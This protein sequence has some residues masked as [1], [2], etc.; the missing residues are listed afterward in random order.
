MMLRRSVV[1]S[2]V[3][4][5][6][7]TAP[8]TS[9]AG[10]D[11]P[12]TVDPYPDAC[13]HIDPTA[14]LLPWPSS[15]YLVD[16]PSTA[17]GRRVAIPAEAMPTDMRGNHVDPA[18]YSGRDGF[19][20][21]TSMMISFPGELDDSL[22]S[23]EEHVPDTLALGSTTVIV[24]METGERVAHFAELDRWEATDPARAPLYLR[25]TERL[26]PNTRYAV[27]IS[28]LRF[29]D[30]S[31]VAPSPY[32]RALRDGTDLAGVDVDA[33]RAEL[34][35]VFVALDG[36]GAPRASL[37]AAW[38][39][40]TGSDEAI[41]SDLIAMRDTALAELGDGLSC[42][43]VTVQDT[44][45]GDTLP[46]GVWR[47]IE[48]TITMP[49]FL[50][51]PSPEVDDARLVR[52]ASGHPILNGTVEAPFLILIPTSVRDRVQAGGEAGRMVV[53]GHGI[54]GERTE[55]DS[56]W[57]IDSASAMGWV[58]IATDW[59]GM[60][61]PDA[62]RLLSTLSASF[63][64]FETTPERLH[65]GVLNTMG[66]MR[67]FSGACAELTELAVPLDDASTVVAYDAEHPMF[68]GNSLGA[69]L[70]GTFA[71]IATDTDRFALGVGGGNWTLLV[72]R[73]DAWRSFDP[74]IA[75]GFPDALTRNLLILMTASLWDPIDSANYAPH[76]L[77]DPLP[78]T[79]IKHVMMQI[80]IGDVAVSNATSLFVARSAGMLLMTPSS[81]D[82]YGLTGVEGTSDS[83]L[84]IYR[85]PGIDAI[86]PGPH[87]PGMSETHN[88][89]RTLP[90]ALLQLDAFL[91]PDGEVIH[92]CD[93]ACDPD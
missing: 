61:R 29:I 36:V 77:S 87:D 15:R 22:L 13:E 25:A 74:L 69:I 85:L 7:E 40:A 79:P 6:C 10:S 33:R 32:F 31:A 59:W 91:R 66:L 86:A 62:G 63:D 34:E 30:G 53:Y 21:L 90:A 73:S 9:D 23:D 37:I 24:D 83:G 51:G 12:V 58:V 82:P 27:G 64:D 43:V 42:T 48:G 84:T 67:S 11:A 56:R 81:I 68:Y 76:W 52:D 44:D 26:R 89:V 93:G 47:R 65:Q 8:P 4:L 20:P 39:F 49:S 38:S 5:A 35:P 80:G 19:S 3:L 41:T 16:D 72:T 28:G 46:D 71:G 14:C 92:S 2:F 60:S 17:T 18:P 55:I 45:A 54:L 70:G 1:L 75:A 78:G 88:G 57:M 50:E